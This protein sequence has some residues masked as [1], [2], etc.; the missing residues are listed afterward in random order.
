MRDQLRA[1]LESSEVF[2][3]WVAVSEALANAEAKI[4]AAEPARSGGGHKKAADIACE[5]IDARG[6]PVPTGELYEAL[7]SAGVTFAGSIP[8]KNL[9]SQLSKCKRLE[10]VQFGPSA[11]DDRG[12]WFKD[13]QIPNR[14][15]KGPTMR[16]VEPSRVNGAA[17]TSA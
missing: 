5:I 15:E 13:R 7:V 1:E 9:C 14:N 12:W 17:D 4:A 11:R 2:I 6:R 10:S 3:S 8:L 16:L